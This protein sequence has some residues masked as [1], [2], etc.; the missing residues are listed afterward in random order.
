MGRTVTR[1]QARTGAH[2]QDKDGAGAKSNSELSLSNI[3]T[4]RISKKK[5]SMSKRDSTGSNLDDSVLSLS[6]EDPATLSQEATSSKL[7]LSD[8]TSTS[9]A[10]LT[11]TATCTEVP[12]QPTSPKPDKPEC[13]IC[14]QIALQPV[15]LPCD[16]IFCFLCIK[17]AVHNGTNSCALCRAPLPRDYIFNPEVISQTSSSDDNSSEEA[18]DDKWYYEG[19]NGGWWE[20]DVRTAELIEEK[21]ND[22]SSDGPLTLELM[23]A[24]Y[25]Y[26]IDLEAMCQRRKDNPNIRRRIKRD[27]EIADK[28]GVAGIV[29]SNRGR[30]DDRTRSTPV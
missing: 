27:K 21:Y 6:L 28:R 29:K 18:A 30:R 24:G 25:I 17:G 10:A 22:T 19:R 3:Q 7:P 4:G 2:S 1:S 20:F 14:L 13:A 26:V 23:I 12:P 8:E 9:T 11:S 16:H 5:R 15:K